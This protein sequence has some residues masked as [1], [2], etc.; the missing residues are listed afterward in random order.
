M[1]KQEISKP[2]P[3][4]DASHLPDALLRLRID[5][6][7]AKK[8]VL[9]DAELSALQKFRRAADYIAAAYSY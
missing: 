5:L 3:P 4:P 6:D 8:T 9:T 1:G 2:N 7:D